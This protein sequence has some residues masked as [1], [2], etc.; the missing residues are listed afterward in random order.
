MLPAVPGSGPAP[1]VAA[2]DPDA[3]AKA[4]KSPRRP[5]PD[6]T[7]GV[8]SPMSA[9]AADLR[10]TGP[11]GQD[12]PRPGGR[13]ASAAQAAGSAR[14][15]PSDFDA[16]FQQHYERLVRALTVVAGDR[17]LAEDAVQEAFVKAH[18]KWRK[19]G[20]YDDPA[21]WVRR[22]ALNRLRDEHRRGVRKLEALG[23]LRR[24]TDVATDTPEID[25]F[26]R[27]LAELPRQQRATTALFYVDELPIDEIA[28]ALGI[29]RGTVKSHLHD[30]RRRLRPLLESATR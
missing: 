28:T 15:A 25:E 4:E 30:A 29:S 22:V 13:L 27:L 14:V 26:G 7:G 11:D 12:A 19:I 9:L 10:S 6:A 8:S 17:V 5:N 1:N 16:L 2:V 18:L 23:R 24:R 20:R 3:R 21:G